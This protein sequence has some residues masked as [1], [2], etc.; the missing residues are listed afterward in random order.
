MSGSPVSAKDVSAGTVDDGTV[1]TS[2]PRPC[3]IKKADTA[4]TTYDDAQSISVIDTSPHSAHAD[5]APSVSA[6]TDAV[7]SVFIFIFV[8]LPMNG[9]INGGKRFLLQ[10]LN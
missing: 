9:D 10:Q 4:V 6:S 5:V 2:Q 8:S 3:A 1:W 7:P